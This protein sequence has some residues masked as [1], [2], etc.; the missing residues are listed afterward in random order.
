MKAARRKGEKKQPQKRGELQ[1]SH[2][3]IK[4]VSANSGLLLGNTPPAKGIHQTLGTRSAQVQNGHGPV[5]CMKP[6]H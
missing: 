1:A 3:C 2:A 5:P 6:K 4:T